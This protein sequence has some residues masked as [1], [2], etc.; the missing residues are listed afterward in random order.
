[1]F[2]CDQAQGRRPPPRGNAGLGVPAAEQAGGEKSVVGVTMLQESPVAESSS[3][4][5]A[6]NAIRHVQGHF[7]NL[8][9]MLDMLNLAD[10]SF[11][12][13]SLY[14]EGTINLIQMT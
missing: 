10:K 9:A 4:G 12:W 3:N 8:K 11:L 13:Q 7:R 14:L 6:E 5:G 1:M 2:S